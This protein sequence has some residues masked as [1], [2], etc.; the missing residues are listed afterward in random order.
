MAM[1]GDEKQ[2]KTITIATNIDPL[3]IPLLN[4][5]RVPLASPNCAI[6]L[7]NSRSQKEENSVWSTNPLPVEY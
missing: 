2:N 5:P 4:E 7:L 6:V 1:H 3:L